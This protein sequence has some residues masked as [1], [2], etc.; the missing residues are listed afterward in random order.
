MPSKMKST[1]LLVMAA[2]LQ[3][4]AWSGWRNAS[5]ANNSALY[6]PPSVHLL[7]GVEYRFKEGVLVGRGQQFHSQYSYERAVI[8][9]N[10]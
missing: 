2:L 8:I 9:G 3:S 6:D 4:C 1:A 7:D 10:K 5:T